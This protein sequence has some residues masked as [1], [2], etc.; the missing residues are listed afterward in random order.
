MARLPRL[1]IPRLPHLLLQRAHNFG[2]LAVDEHDAQAWQA[3]LHQASRDQAVQVHGYGLW[4][5]G[6]LLLLTPE[7]AGGLSRL[8]Q[9]VG[10]RYGA[11]FNRRHGRS[12]GLWDGR[13]RTTVVD[14]AESLLDALLMVES[15]AGWQA[16]ATGRRVVADTP[17]AGGLVPPQW[18]S[19]DHHLGRRRD[20]VVQEAAA[21]WA[22]GNTPFERELG[23]KRRLDAG[24]ATRRAQSLADAVD[25]GW[26]LGGPPGDG[27]AALVEAA[28]P[29]RLQP[30]RRGRPRKAVVAPSSAT[31]GAA[32]GASS[33]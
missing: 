2:C 6:F 18:S 7:H 8:M 24:L 14:P 33:D 31:A 16:L 3:A 13:F 1:E 28:T 29:R 27:F 11:H 17:A 10:R 23:W 9:S 5:Q 32:P 26:V 12:G 30:L 21:W 19:R 15:E 4:P 22:L 25:K 20:P